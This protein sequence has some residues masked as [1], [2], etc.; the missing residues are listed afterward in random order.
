MTAP[1]ET[2]SSRKRRE[3]VPTPDGHKVCATCKEDKVLEDFV[4][5]IN[6]KD[7]RGSECLECCRKRRENYYL[8]N[9]E[10]DAEQKRLGKS[11]TVKERARWNKMERVYGITKEQYEAQ[12]AAQGGKCAICRRVNRHKTKKYLSIDHNHET[13]E[14]RGLLCHSCNV[15]IGLFTESPEVLKAAVRYLMKSDIDRYMF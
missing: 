8:I 5:Q 13:G 6:K 11:G 9:P 4:Q 3:R 2:I 7:K 12:F 14:I 1:T 10:K 15:A